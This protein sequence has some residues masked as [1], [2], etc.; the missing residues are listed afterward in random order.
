MS[1][2]TKKTQLT[3]SGKPRLSSILKSDWRMNYELYIL[4]IPVLVFYILFHYKPIYGAIIAFKD[5]N[6]VKGIMGSDW[7]GFKH[8]VDFFNSLSFWEVLRNTVRISVSSILVNFPAPIILALLINEIRQKK[9]ASCVKTVSYFPHFISL[10]VSCAM[11]K[12]FVAD[13]GLIGGFV[14]SITGGKVSLLNDPDY[15]TAV[16]VGSGLW[17]EVGW[18]SI[19]YVSALSA[20]DQQLYEAARIDGANRWG[21]LIHVTIPGILPTIIIMLILKLGQLLSVGYEKIILLY[22]PLTYEKADVILSYVYR[23]GLQEFG[24]SFSTAVGLFN[25]TINFL[26]LVLVNYI[27]KK[28]SE[29]SLW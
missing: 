13:T 21:E 29:I 17:Q 9:F 2:A 3:K 18:S 6:P 7:V 27:S 5:F 4:V 28:V 23:K 22:N 20:V 10:V 26:F 1:T 24:Y 25:S 14:N 19:I 16:Y 8:F 12:Y 15:F 11:I